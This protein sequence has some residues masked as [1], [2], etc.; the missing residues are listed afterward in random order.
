MNLLDEV[1]Q[2]LAISGATW[3]TAVYL[4]ADKSYSSEDLL[5]ATTFGKLANLTLD[6]IRTP[7]GELIK[8]A[9]ASFESYLFAAFAAAGAGLVDLSKNFEA[10]IGGAYF[11][12]FRLNGE[13][14]Q[15]PGLCTNANKNQIYVES[16]R[17]LNIIKFRNPKLNV[18]N[19]LIKQRTKVGS[20]VMQACLLSPVGYEPIGDSIVAVRFS[21]DWSGFPYFA[22]EKAVNF[23]ALNT[24]L[25]GSLPTLENVLVGGGV[26]EWWSPSHLWGWRSL[27]GNPESYDP[28]KLLPQPWML[29]Q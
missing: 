1:D 23:T 19:A 25:F 28:T 29:V 27:N 2:I 5:G 21:P 10:A 6:A 18:S 12:P 9:N 20:F 7:H 16:E 11:C 4:F 26:V 3:A 8:S 15:W 13:L 14:P 24:S 22:D 17:Q